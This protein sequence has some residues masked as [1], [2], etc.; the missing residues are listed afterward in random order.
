LIVPAPFV[1]RDVDLLTVAG[2]LAHTGLFIGHD[3]GITHLSALLAVPTVALFGP[4]C[5]QRWAP[6]G[7]HVRIVRG[8]SCTCS[9]WSHV[10]RCNDKPCL[11]ISAVDILSSCCTRP[12]IGQSL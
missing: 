1:L 4:T 5:P 8:A 2:A 6:T 7:P 11:D 3:S 10:R 12:L 9:D